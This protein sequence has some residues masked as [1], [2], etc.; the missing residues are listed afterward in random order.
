MIVVRLRFLL[1][2]ERLSV[3]RHP[4]PLVFRLVSQ[5][6]RQA[7]AELAM[8]PS[9]IH[10]RRQFPELRGTLRVSLTSVLTHASRRKFLSRAFPQD[11]SEA[12]S[13][14]QTQAFALESR[15]ISA[16]ARR[17]VSPFSFSPL[18]FLRRCFWS[19]RAAARSPQ[20]LVSFA[21]TDSRRLIRF[22]SGTRSQGNAQAFSNSCCPLRCLKSGNAIL[23][24][25][26]LFGRFFPE[27]VRPVLHNASSSGGNHIADGGDD[28]GNN[29][30]HLLSINACRGWDSGRVTSFTECKIAGGTSYGRERLSNARRPCRN[31][32]LLK[33]ACPLPSPKIKQP[34]SVPSEWRR[35]VR[36]RAYQSR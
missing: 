1:T 34:P 19:H 6:I 28:G 29:Q 5:P 12:L 3:A 21:H 27:N 35:M 36:F 22:R 11:R 30:P 24:R 26:N 7:V 31:N 4:W 2:Q 13:L 8:R 10:D 9:R 32:Q 23:K 15:S 17:L 25:T 14:A 16:A 33:F 20:T 18:V